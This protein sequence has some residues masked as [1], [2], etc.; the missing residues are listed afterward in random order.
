MTL[1]SVSTTSFSQSRQTVDN[2]TN[3]LVAT[4]YE[5]CQEHVPGSQ[6]FADCMLE[7][8]EGGLIGVFGPPKFKETNPLLLVPP[9]YVSPEDDV[10]TEGFWIQYD[11][12]Y[13]NEWPFRWYD[14]SSQKK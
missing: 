9:R 7:I 12:F 1:L 14:P 11:D 10:P 13:G 3:A 2:L 4:G 6:E 5:M 8:V